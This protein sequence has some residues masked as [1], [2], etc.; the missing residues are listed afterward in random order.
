M[1]HGFSLEFLERLVKKLC[2][3]PLDSG[4]GKALALCDSA[5]NVQSKLL[6]KPAY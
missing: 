1:F 5:N 3:H 6:K 4:G 2:G